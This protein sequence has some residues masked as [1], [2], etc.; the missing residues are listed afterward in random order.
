[1]SQV[2]NQS[3][4]VTAEAALHHQS[5][6]QH[7]AQPLP[8]PHYSHAPPMA[9]LTAAPPGPPPAHYAPPPPRSQKSEKEKMLCGEPFLPF[10]PQL[11]EERERCKAAAYRFNNSDNPQKDI[12]RDSRDNLFRAILAAR[13]ALAYTEPGKQPCG[14]FGREGVFIETPFMCEYGYN[15]SIGDNVDIG[16][17]CKFLDSGRITIGRNST[18]G[19]NVTIDTQRTPPDVKYIKGSRRTAVAAEVHIG[20]NVH[21]GSNCTILAGVRIGAGAIIH[22]GSVVVRVSYP[23]RTEFGSMLTIM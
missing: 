23:T 2:V 9:P 4:V 3:P 6:S 5:Q 16:T 17:S 18:I 22:P 13:W 10:S 20:E 15:I 21:I 11:I 12:G 19:A 7:Q 8:L 14:H 1:M